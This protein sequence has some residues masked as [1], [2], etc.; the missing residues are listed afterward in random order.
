MGL[1]TSN[2][3]IVHASTHSFYLKDIKLAS[4]LM[5]SFNSRTD[6]KPIY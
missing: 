5:Q 3:R 6:F 2:A 1:V 4:K